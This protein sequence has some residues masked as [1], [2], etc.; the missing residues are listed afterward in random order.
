VR[1]VYVRGAAAVSAFGFGWRG[2]GCALRDHGLD[3]APSQQLARS[4][5]RVLASEVATIPAELDVDPRARKLM[6]HPAR[7]AAV[8]LR[9]A[10]HDADLQPT[11]REQCALY[12]G[13]GASG[14]SM[15]ELAR[16][17]AASID[18]EQFQLDRFGK[19][20]LA[21]CNP[22]FAF[23]LMNNF[24]MCH[25]A[26]LNGTAGPNGAFYSRGTGTVAALAEA[27]WLVG[28]G[29]CEFAIAGGA[30]SALHPVTW[31]QLRGDGYAEL[32]LVPGEGA[33]LL[34]LSA[35][36]HAALA[37]VERTECVGSRVAAESAAGLLAD[38]GRDDLIVIAPWGTPARE[39]AGSRAHLDISHGLGDALAAGPALAWCAAL[40]LLQAGSCKRAFILGAGIDGGLGLVVLG[41]TQ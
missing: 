5:G 2:L 16:M 21:A 13:V 17:L 7:L 30:D 20:G 35:S 11:D 25:G 1:P 37:T 36:P 41:R 8:A 12:L 19:D 3:Y 38:A 34:V 10:L 31:S 39:L 23:Q 18:E 14:C 22:L 28:S 26:I 15:D 32:G 29:E 24:T 9:L 40:D 6:S 33:G 27:H 4:H